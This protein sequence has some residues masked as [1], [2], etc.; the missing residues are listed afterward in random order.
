MYEVTLD[1]P[2][3]WTKP[4]TFMLPTAKSDGNVYEYACPEGNYYMANM[5][6]GQ[7]AEGNAAAAVKK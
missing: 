2:T 4:W 7:L 5:L 1:D 6:R 3:T